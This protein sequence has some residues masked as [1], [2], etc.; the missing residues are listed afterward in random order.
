MQQD[1]F[2]QSI[3]V[4]FWVIVRLNI[5]WYRV[6]QAIVRHTHGDVPGV[7]DI[8]IVKYRLRRAKFSSPF[9]LLKTRET[10]PKHPALNIDSPLV[11]IREQPE[12]ATPQLQGIDLTCVHFCV[13][14]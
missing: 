2:V 14:P 4:V 11:G 6:A 3:W 7:K 9:E 8:V 1:C 10:I 13:Y 12:Q 5:K